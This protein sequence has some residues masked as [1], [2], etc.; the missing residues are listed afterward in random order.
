[1]YDLKIFHAQSQS[2]AAENDFFTLFIL[3]DLAHIVSL[4]FSGNRWKWKNPQYYF[5]EI[6]DKI[7][8]PLKNAK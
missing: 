2:T 5:V 4:V 8:D 3:K 1:M 7:M 6:L